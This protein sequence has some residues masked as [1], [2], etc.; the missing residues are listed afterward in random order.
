LRLLYSEADV[1]EAIE[2]TR[3]RYRPDRIATLFVGES[4]PASGKFFYYG[5]TALEREMARAMTAAG[6]VRSDDDFLEQFKGY[7]WF[8]DDVALTPVNRLGRSA[9]KKQCWDAQKSLA[10]RI[11]KYRPRA[12]VSLML[13]IKD[14]VEGA[15]IAAGSGAPRYAVPFPGNGQQMRF[16]REMAHILPLL[17]LEGRRSG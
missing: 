12:I 13:G 15:A 8:L 17:P 14:I 3:A 9:R 1:T 2:S 11:A 10:N 5:N 7:G 4:A 6:L 16:R